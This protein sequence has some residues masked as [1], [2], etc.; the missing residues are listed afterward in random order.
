[1]LSENLQHC[2]E[3]NNAHQGSIYLYNPHVTHTMN[4]SLNHHRHQR[5]PPVAHHCLKP[6]PHPPRVPSKL[7]I[8]PGARIFVGGTTRRKKRP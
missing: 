1:V 8:L 6:S 7:P 4:Q 3:R 2:L 5:A